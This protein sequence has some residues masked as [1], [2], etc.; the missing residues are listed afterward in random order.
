MFATG[1]HMTTPG[2]RLKKAR[3]SCG[4]VTAKDAAIAMG[5]PIAT[6]T[7]HEAATKH[8]PSRRADEY[9]A[10]FKITPEYLLY[11]RGAVPPRVPVLDANGRDTGR[12]A[13]MP[14]QPS[15]LTRAL[16]T[17]DGD[18]IAHFGFVAIYNHP[19]ARKPATELHGRVCVVSVQIND[20][21]RQLVRIIQP[22]TREG[23]YHL[24]G[25]AMP[26][27]DHAVLWCA[28]VVAFVP[29]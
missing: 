22:G 5:V 1:D 18:G 20:A 14:P 12:T 21:P 17:T 24:I 10:F 3:E 29:L 27:I 16:L 26:L 8:L 6:Y 25:G 2:A 11:G 13:A 19:Q 7:Q 23:R 4:F 28:P 15:E 9:A